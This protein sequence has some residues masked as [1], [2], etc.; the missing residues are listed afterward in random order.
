MLLG[1]PFFFHTSINGESIHAEEP[2]TRLCLYLSRE[3][4]HRQ[5]I[6]AYEVWCRITSAGESPLRSTKITSPGI[7][8]SSKQK[9]KTNLK[10]LMFYPE[11]Q[12][13]FL[14]WLVDFPIPFPLTCHSP[15]FAKKNSE[16]WPNH[17]VST[18][19]FFYIGSPN[20]QQNNSNM[21][22]RFKKN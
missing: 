4:W 18:L 13:C 5:S 19:H 17:R 22:F 8:T 2:S 16:F 15:R 14:T 6:G 10:C 21:H 12:S 7:K 20:S 9:Q 1:L 3:V 11:P